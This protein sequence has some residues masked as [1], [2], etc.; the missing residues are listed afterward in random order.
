MK[1]LAL[2]VACGMAL[3][4]PGC[5]LAAAGAGAAGGVYVEKNY[6]ISVEKKKDEKSDD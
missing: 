5:L 3:T 2:W 1:Y 4:S 6:D